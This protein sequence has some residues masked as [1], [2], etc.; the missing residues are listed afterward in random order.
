MSNRQLDA[1]LLD[2]EEV[3]QNIYMCFC[4]KM[5]MEI[6]GMDEI[7]QK[8]EVQTKKVQWFRAEF[9]KSAAFKGQEDEPEE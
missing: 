8:A 7:A 6:L 2:S 4:V 9:S 5:G 1:S 3:G